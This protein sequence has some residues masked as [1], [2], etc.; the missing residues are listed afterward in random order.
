MMHVV[1]NF[2]VGYTRQHIKY[3]HACTMH[4]EGRIKHNMRWIYLLYKMERTESTDYKGKSVFDL[5]SMQ[6]KQ[7]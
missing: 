2:Y 4:T 7:A 3:I 5:V 1:I 6:L